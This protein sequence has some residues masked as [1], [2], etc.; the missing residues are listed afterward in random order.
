MTGRFHHPATHR[1]A[2]DA[3]R[4]LLAVAPRQA[5]DEETDLRLLWDLANR[6]LPRGVE[7][8]KAIESVDRVWDV[9]LVREI[10]NLHFGGV[11]VL[12]RGELPDG[13]VAACGRTQHGALNA[14][15]FR[16]RT[17]AHV[18]NGWVPRGGP[19]QP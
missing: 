9:Y 13:H 4:R 19:P 5:S 10:P 16:R 12:Y 8:V 14:E 18:V 15:G 1:I 3:L 7:I 6:W 11:Q 2:V 17:L